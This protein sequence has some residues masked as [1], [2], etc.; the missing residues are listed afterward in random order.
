MLDHI[1]T[2]LC[3]FLGLAILLNGKIKVVLLSVKYAV[4]ILL[5]LDVALM[6]STWITLSST[7]KLVW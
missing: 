1:L 4:L 5:G 2:L 7:P 3:L 6:H